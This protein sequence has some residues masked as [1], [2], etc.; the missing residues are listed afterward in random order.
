MPLTSADS[1]FSNN[2]CEQICKLY[3]HQTQKRS[4][5]LL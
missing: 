3:S 2:I 1:G 4:K 5:N